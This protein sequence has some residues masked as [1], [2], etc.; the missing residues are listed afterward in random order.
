MSNKKLGSFAELAALTGTPAAAI[1]PA[2]AA[3][4]PLSADLVYATDVGRIAAP[5]ATT[6]PIADGKCVRVQRE[7]QGRGGKVVTVVRGLPLD[8]A[9]LAQLLKELKSKLGGGGCVKEGQLELQG[10]HRERLVL[11]L[12]ERGYAAKASGG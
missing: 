11:L 7:K 6:R 4:R 12:N 3:Q 2:T 10:D 8:D 5:A 9:A 1:S